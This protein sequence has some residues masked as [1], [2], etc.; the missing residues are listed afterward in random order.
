MDRTKLIELLQPFKK[1]CAEKGKP[2]DDL[3]IEEAFPGD[4]S[5]SYIIRVK[6]TW[7]D[8]ILCSEALDF[9]FDILWETTD[10]E[11]RRK[12]FTIQVVNSEGELHCW[13]ERPIS[14]D[15]KDREPQHK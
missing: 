4:A 12:V 14:A 5:T 10:E 11:T 15:I 13:S 7:V 6:A 2:L 3:C 1:K 8:N 9:L